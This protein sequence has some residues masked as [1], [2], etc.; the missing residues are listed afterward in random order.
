MPLARSQDLSPRPILGLLEI[1]KACLG[2]RFVLV[3][4]EMDPSNSLRHKILNSPGIGDLAAFL[5]C[6]QSSTVVVTGFCLGDF[7]N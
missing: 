7:Q 3:I 6:N 1:R 2:W 4:T 5:S